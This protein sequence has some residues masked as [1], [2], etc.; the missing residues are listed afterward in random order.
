MFE[1]F[2]TTF[3]F[4]TGQVYKYEYFVLFKETEKER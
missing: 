2:T 4:Y 3:T 1:N